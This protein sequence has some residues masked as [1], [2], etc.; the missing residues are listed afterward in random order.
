[1][2]AEN[3]EHQIRVMSVTD[4]FRA[5]LEE[6]LGRVEPVTT[7]RMFGGLGVYARGLFFALADDNVVYFKGG[8]ANMA[9]FEARGCEPFRPYG[10]ERSMRYFTVPGEVLEDVE[11]LADWMEKALTV[12][13]DAKR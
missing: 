10:D 13:R 4:A 7:R 11:L 3:V 6:Q 12:A 2:D 8:D 9:D 1:M 5:Y